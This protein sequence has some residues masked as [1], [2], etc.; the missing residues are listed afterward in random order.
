MWERRAGAAKLRLEWSPGAAVFVPAG[1]HLW[2]RRECRVPSRMLLVVIDP[3]ALR[4]LRNVNFDTAGIQFRPHYPL[5]DAA[6][7]NILTAIRDELEQPGPGGLLYR[8]SLIVQLLIRLVQTASNFDGTG[9]NTLAKGGL[10][11]WQLRKVFG[12]I[13]SDPARSPSLEQLG[14]AV[15][16]S[17]RHL[18]RAFRESVGVPP[19][20]YIIQRRI[21]R[22][23]ELMRD[24][25]LRLTDIAL[26]TGFGDASSFSRSFRRFTGLAPRAYRKL[27]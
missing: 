19:R 15:R 12:L 7:G 24:P 21:E 2:L 27:V 13:D 10:A 23:K 1:V 9:G 8:E 4:S 3:E 20:R 25:S 22:A 5:N 6:I 17:G 26:S 14:S 11:G 18:C 16:I